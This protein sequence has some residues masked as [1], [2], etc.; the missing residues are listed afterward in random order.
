LLD[1]F[2]ATS[3]KREFEWATAQGSNV[4]W[5]PEARWV[6]DGN[7]WTASGVTAGIDMALALIADLH[8]EELAIEVADG[9]EYEWHRDPSS[10]PFAHNRSA[11]RQR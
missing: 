10:D 4:E 2:R 9:A 8:G 5:V 11:N 6:V 3:N 1:G 7:R